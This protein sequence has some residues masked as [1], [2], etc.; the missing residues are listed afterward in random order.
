MGEAGEV[1]HNSD[2]IPFGRT[3]SSFLKLIILVIYMP[4][5]ASIL[6]PDFFTP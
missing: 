5:V 6:L 2:K 3:E 4:N 1:T